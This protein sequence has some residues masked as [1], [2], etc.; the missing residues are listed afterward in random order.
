MI[1]HADRG[2]GTRHH[3]RIEK[4]FLASF[5]ISILYLRDY[6][7]ILFLG[8]RRC[9]IQRN[10]GP[11]AKWQDIESRKRCSVHAETGAYPASYPNKVVS[12]VFRV[13]LP[14]RD[15]SQ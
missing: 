13:N 6:K 12:F 2:V 14:K 15:A 3:M 1:F 4:N 11:R 9:T 8:E 5:A 7:H 10:D